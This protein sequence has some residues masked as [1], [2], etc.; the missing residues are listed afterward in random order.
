[1]AVVLISQG[2]PEGGYL[3]AE[4]RFLDESVRPDTGHELVF[5]DDLARAFDKN[6]QYFNSP[7]RQRND[8]R[9]LPQNVARWI[10]N[11]TAELVHENLSE[12]DHRGDRGPDSHCR[13]LMFLFS[14]VR[15]LDRA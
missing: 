15:A 12:F 11:E 14:S 13:N 6:G 4:I 8:V 5:R 9:T 7:E 2:F 1:M 10:E 3:N